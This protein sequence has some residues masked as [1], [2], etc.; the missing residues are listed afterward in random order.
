[1]RSIIGCSLALAAVLFTGCA[2]TRSFKV[3]AISTTTPVTARTYHIVPANP[4]IPDN[5]LRF[6][7]AAGVVENALSSR[8]YA[9]R[10]ESQSAD[11]VIA[12]EASVGQ[13][14]TVTVSHPSVEAADLGF[15]H[16]VRVP[17]RNRAG[18]VCFVR[19]MVWAPNYAYVES[20]H[21]ST[22][23]LYEKRLALTA[24][25]NNGAEDL[26]QLWSVVVMERGESS[27]IRSLMPMMAVTAAKYIESDTKGQVISRLKAEDPEVLRISPAKDGA[28]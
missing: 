22:S 25:A 13:P 24:F 12:L 26:P 10:A 14:E 16:S 27:D 4:Q 6:I 19:T 15:Y 3:D 28:K 5:D 21:I 1:M 23:T 17:V 2:T 7:E 18:R 8:G 20:E 9:R 11:L